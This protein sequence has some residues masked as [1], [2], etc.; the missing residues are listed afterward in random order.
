MTA[1][2][3]MTNLV[4]QTQQQTLT[5]LKQ[6]HDL[7]IRAGEIA[8]G[9]IPGDAAAAELPTPKQVVEST[10]SFAGQLLEAQKNYALRLADVVS[11]AAEK[12]PVRTGEHTQS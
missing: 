10:F 4:S 8:V 5:A 2:T 9:L 1:T 3:E 7:S 11:K 12:T 6:A